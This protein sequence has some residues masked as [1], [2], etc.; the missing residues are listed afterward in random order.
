MEKSTGK[1]KARKLL[2]KLIKIADMKFPERLQIE[3]LCTT[4]FSETEFT[5]H[6]V[7]IDPSL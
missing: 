2:A 7:P 1:S 4:E 5:E 3:L 6:N